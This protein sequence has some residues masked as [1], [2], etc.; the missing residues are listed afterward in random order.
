MRNSSHRITTSS[1]PPC[2]PSLISHFI[3][4]CIL[5]TSL[6]TCNPAKRTLFHS[7]S[8]Y[9]FSI[10]PTFSPIGSLIPSC[11]WSHWARV[12]RLRL[13]PPSKRHP[14]MSL[15]ITLFFIPPQYCTYILS[16]CWYYWWWTTYFKRPSKYSSKVVPLFIPANSGHIPSSRWS[17]EDL[18]RMTNF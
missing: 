17:F 18:V 16:H 11:I 15:Y 9:I 2:Y 12:I 4:P 14:C 13:L 8:L 7:M 1:H 5:T 6:N 3:L 10:L